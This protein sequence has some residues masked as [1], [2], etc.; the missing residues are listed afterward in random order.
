MF[1]INVGITI[2]LLLS[3]AYLYKQQTQPLSRRLEQ[4]GK[5]AVIIA[6]IK[7]S[8]PVFNISKEQWHH[9]EN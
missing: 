7:Y 9:W 4:Y 5:L 6:S 1:S 3:S 2:S 8:L